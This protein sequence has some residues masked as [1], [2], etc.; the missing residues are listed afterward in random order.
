M[1]YCERGS[2]MDSMTEPKVNAMLDELKSRILSCRKDHIPIYVGIFKDTW[3]YMFGENEVPE[4][5]MCLIHEWIAD[6][7]N[8][9]RIG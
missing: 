8:S 5:I 9:K 1:L 4:H 6:R 2:L 7:S 3:H